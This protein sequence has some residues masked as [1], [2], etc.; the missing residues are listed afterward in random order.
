MK[1]YKVAVLGASGGIGQPLSL[2]LKQSPL[3]SNLALYDIAHVKGVAVDL[4]HIETVPK[5]S[6]HLGLEELPGCLSGSDIVIIPAGVP[7]KPGTE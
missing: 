5:V 3:I 1:T 4:S 7:R 2:F 6:S